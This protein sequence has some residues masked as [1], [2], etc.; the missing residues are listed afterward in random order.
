[1]GYLSL[2]RKWRPKTFG[3]LA[4]Q[5]TVVKTLKN[6][7]ERDRIAHAYLFCGPR[8]TGKT[9]TA[10]LFA[11][12]LNCEQGPTTEPCNECFS[13]QQ[14]N[15]GRSV[16][17]IEI[18]AASNRRIDEIRDLRDKVKFAPSEGDY[19]VYIIDE[20]HMLT[21]E[22]FNALLKTLEEPPENVVFIL[23]TTEP[24][25]I[26][27]T[28]LSR[29]QR[30]DFTLHSLSDLKARM[31][32][33]SEQEGVPITDGALSLISRAAEGGMRDAISILDQ[34][35]A[36]GGDQ[37]TIEDV[38]TILGKVDQRI[39]S[40][41][42]EVIGNHDTEGVLRVLNEILDQGKDMNQFV[43]DLLFHFR[44]LM[45][46]K[47]CGVQNAI[48]ELP[49]ELK[50]ELRVQAE[51]FTM[52]ELLRL[53]DILSETD[54]K[55]KFSSQ[56][57][58]VLEMSMIQMVSA[59]VDTSI[60][61]LITRLSR[62]EEMVNGGQITMIS[63]ADAT[64]SQGDF[65]A[66]LASEEKKV[67]EKKPTMSL[68]EKKAEIERNVLK[69]TEAAQAQ[70]KAEA[71]LDGVARSKLIADDQRKAS[72]TQFPQHEEPKFE[73]TI[74]SGAGEPVAPSTS[75]S[76]HAGAP[77]FSKDEMTNYWQVTLELLD[78]YM[79]TKKL[80]AVLKAG[81]FHTIIGNQVFVVFPKSSTFHKSVAEK[82]TDLLCRALKKV[83]GQDLRA[84][85]IFEG[86]E[87]REQ[88][89]GEGKPQE[90]ATDDDEL[91]TQL[92]RQE[93]ENDPIIQKAL[94]YFGGKIIQVEKE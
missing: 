59:E 44:D 45:F 88:A 43:K 61:S 54:Q 89:G 19:K 40:K 48:I 20:V 13:C 83:T 17:V 70:N 71:K 69:K 65:F 49:D 80:A 27:P 36:F 78:K 14:I 86:E 39:M 28:I 67:Q 24:H 57:R 42:V 18:D 37:V 82:G 32:F 33:I 56:P 60:T 7:L 4:G 38:N 25:K 62:L 30:F 51:R 35:I 1:M 79:Q 23:A 8:G 34:A 77:V 73:Q 21:K 5:V 94:K 74:H 66:P 93:A 3:D 90:P 76:I 87:P 91:P 10:K 9:S 29:C 15:T 46:I 84:I 81:E 11:K 12:A 53:L 2:Y 85:C 50:E 58:L 16:D 6:A 31:Q 26:I 64:D 47:E 63:K 68:E 55:L 52:K 72:E 22:A 92:S 75:Q 41:V